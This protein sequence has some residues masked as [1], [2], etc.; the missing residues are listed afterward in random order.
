MITPG[1]AHN[2]HC[3]LTTHTREPKRWG[4]VATTLIYTSWWAQVQTKVRYWNC[5]FPHVI[6]LYFLRNLH[7]SFR[8]ARDHLK[9]SWEARI[10]YNLWKPAPFLITILFLFLSRTCLPSLGSPQQV[11]LSC[12]P[13]GK[14]NLPFSF[15]PFP[16]DARSP[17]PIPLS[18]P[19]FFSSCPTDQFFIFFFFLLILGCN[20][21]YFFPSPSLF[22][23]HHTV[24]LVLFRF[25]EL[26]HCTTP[27]PHP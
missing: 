19:H 8:K 12:S 18:P 13:D 16:P 1:R 14:M 3:I 20:I 5:F 2:Q 10:K 17:P 7:K 6:L 25:K 21:F 24:S 11:D 27:H 23:T 26:N 22:S 4:T 9:Q 15:L